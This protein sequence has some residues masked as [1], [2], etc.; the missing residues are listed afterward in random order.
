VLKLEDNTPFEAQTGP[1]RRGDHQTIKKH[2]KYLQKFP[3]YTQLYTLLT[4]SIEHAY[5]R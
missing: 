3:E 1:A 2:L 5:R 4:K